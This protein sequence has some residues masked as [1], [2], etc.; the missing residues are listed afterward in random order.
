MMPSFIIDEE[1][2][3]VSIY[4]KKNNLLLLAWDIPWLTKK[5]GS[6]PHE[7][8]EAGVVILWVMLQ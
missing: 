1:K 6:E 7:L 2:S 8:D 5:D 4:D 3:G